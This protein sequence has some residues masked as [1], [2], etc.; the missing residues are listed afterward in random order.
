MIFVSKRSAE[1]RHDP[2]AHDL[3]DGAFV[4]MDRFHHPF[5]DRVEEIPCLLGI[6]I[7]EQLHRALEVSEK[8]GDLLALAF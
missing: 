3:V 8:H 4:S 7:S 5:E 6:T 2:I 1:Q